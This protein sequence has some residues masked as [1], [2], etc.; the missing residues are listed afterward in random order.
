MFGY[1][2]H[3]ATFLGALVGYWVRSHGQQVQ[4][5][6]VVSTSFWTV[7]TASLLAEAYRA[8]AGP[9]AELGITPYHHSRSDSRR[10][11]HGG[12][13]GGLIHEYA[14]PPDVPEYLTPTGVRNNGNGSCGTPRPGSIVADHQ[15]ATLR[16]CACGCGI[17][18]GTACLQTRQGAA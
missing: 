11:A 2:T 17:P 7:A 12:S 4:D 8:G 6:V 10:A 9:G 18:S 3:T 1:L 16:S 13:H 14:R 5:Q 15:P